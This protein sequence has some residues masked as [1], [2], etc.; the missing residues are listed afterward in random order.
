MALSQEKKSLGLYL[1]V[2]F[3]VQKCRYCDFYSGPAG[4][5]EREA[6]VAALVA[7]LKHARAAARDFTL[8]TVY[9]GGGTPSLLSP[10]QFDAILHTVK[11]C[12]DLATDAEITA[13]CNPVTAA[14]VLL[15]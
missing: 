12:F 5:V 1:H 6:Y 7:H 2:P 4:E 3:C 10:A 9:F 15:E 11:G 14:D 8:D 13:S